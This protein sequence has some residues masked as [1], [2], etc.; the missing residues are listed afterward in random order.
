MLVDRMI[1][2]VKKLGDYDKYVN[3]QFFVIY[4]KKNTVNDFCFTSYVIHY[5]HLP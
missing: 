3:L 5:T 2:F 4:I 1:K